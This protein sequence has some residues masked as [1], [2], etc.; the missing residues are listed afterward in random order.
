MRRSRHSRASTTSF[1]GP[2]WSILGRACHLPPWWRIIGDM[3]RR[4]WQIDLR[5]EDEATLLRARRAL[6]AEGDSETGRALLGLFAKIAAAIEGGAVISF[7]PGD[8]PRAVD[9][10]PEVTR[11]LR[12]E[13]RYR[14]LVLSRTTGASSF[15]SRGAGS[16]P[17][18]WYPRWK[19][20]DS[21]S[22]MRLPIGISTSKPSPK[23]STMSR[24]IANSSKLS[25]PRNAAGPSRS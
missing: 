4:R 16:R 5:P 2:V 17:V 7:L 18:N 21:R 14:W 22:K 25:S 12:P 13:T 8:D 15:R 11:A 23:R 24:G 3:G 19:R 1:W 20:T 6:A 9:A 10:L